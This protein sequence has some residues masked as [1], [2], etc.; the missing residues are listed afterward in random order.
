[1]SLSQSHR[2]NAFQCLTYSPCLTYSRL[3][4][5]TTD[6]LRIIALYVLYRDGV[7]DEDKRRLY[8]H[9]RLGLHEMDA[10]NN[11]VHLGANVA[12][13]SG[14]KRKQLFKQPLNEND[15]DISRYQPLVKL[16][17]EVAFARKPKQ[18][19]HLFEVQTLT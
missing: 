7:P 10:V 12:K 6:K 13:D 4:N 16:M 11:L 2:S 3:S 18:S 1:M 14:K 9:A 19:H 8:Q 15:Y 17:L 5:S